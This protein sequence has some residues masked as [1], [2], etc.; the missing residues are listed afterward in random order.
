MPL[1]MDVA[2]AVADDTH[3]AGKRKMDEVGVM[4]TSN[5][6]TLPMLVFVS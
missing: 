3:A 2:V 1:N 6:A 4:A 5:A